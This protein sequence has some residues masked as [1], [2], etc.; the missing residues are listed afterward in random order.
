MR[1]L[2]DDPMRRDFRLAWDVGQNIF[3]KNSENARGAFLTCVGWNNTCLGIQHPWVSG[4]HPTEVRLVPLAIGWN[5][6]H[7]QAV[8]RVAAS[9][10]WVTQASM[11]P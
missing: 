10:T 7:Y 6:K 4:L 9:F 2:G 1:H 3:E 8:G 11:P 5:R